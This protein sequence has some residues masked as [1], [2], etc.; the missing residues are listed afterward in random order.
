MQTLEE[1]HPLLD[2]REDH[3][4]GWK[5]NEWELKGVPL[6]I[7]VGPRDVAQQQAI[8][9]RR[10]TGKKTAVSMGKIHGEVRK[11]VDAMQRDLFRGAQQAQAALIVEVKGYEQ[12]KKAVQQQKFGRA[13]FCNVRACE[14]RI[15]GAEGIKNICLL[16][17]A[18]PAG[19]AVCFNCGKQATAIGIFGRTY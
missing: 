4:P 2:D 10:D 17:D 3:T 5:F 9:V 16:L 13:A 18:R 11:L 7:E 14:E 8:I 15:L 6:R 1:F 19:K 12:L